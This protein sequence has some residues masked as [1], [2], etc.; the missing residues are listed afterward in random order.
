MNK[1]EVIELLDANQNQRGIEHWAKMKDTGGLKSFGIGLT[2]LRKLAKKV[3][4]NHDLALELWDS[5]YYDAKVIGLLIDEPKKL[6]REQIEGQV[7]GL[8]MG[9][10]V[11]VFASCDATLPKAPFA[12]ELAAEWLDSDDDL[13][14]RCAYGLY[15]ELSKNQRNKALTDEYFIACIEKIKARYQDDLSG[16]AKVGMGTALMGIGKRNVK[17][18]GIA[19]A[20]AQTIG[21]IDFNDDGGK[22]DPMNVVKHLT[23]DYLKKKLGLS[24]D[25]S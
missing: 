20:L 3:G 19:L 8:G 18:N 13:R 12:V 15:Y 10:L 4:R 14:R 16:G 25:Q 1:S 5:E 6:T 22:C 7:E 2:Q 24:D 17:L 23:S 11:H 9:M 21:P